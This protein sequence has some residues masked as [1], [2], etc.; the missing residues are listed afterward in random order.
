MNLKQPALGVVSTLLVSAVSL[1]F[2]SLFD[3][4]TFAG[5]IS[6]YLTCAVTVLVMMLALWR[7]EHPRFAAA[8][9]QPLKGVLTTLVALAG[10]QAQAA[11]A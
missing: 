7:T 11:I 8:H 5:W 2:V 10:Q 6:F 9:A 3:F 4:P 1:A